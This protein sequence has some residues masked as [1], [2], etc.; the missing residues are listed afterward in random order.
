[1]RHLGEVR[2]RCGLG[3]EEEVSGLNRRSALFAIC[4]G[5]M[6]PRCFCDSG[7]RLKQAA[8]AESVQGLWHGIIVRWSC[9]FWL[10]A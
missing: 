2:R 8:P 6:L 7:A 3:G 1:M 9:I 4:L 5:V 10:F